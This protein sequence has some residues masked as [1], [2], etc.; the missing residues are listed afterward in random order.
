MKS[1]LARR[2]AREIAVQ[3]L[4][5]MEMNEVTAEVALR[6]AL[7]ELIEEEDTV[8]VDPSDD[9]QFLRSI[10]NGTS[11][12]V[13]QIDGVLEGYLTGWKMD[14]LS[15]VDRQIL[16]LGAYEMFFEE[17]TPDAVI[18]N[19]AIELAKHFG[20]DESGKFVNGVLGQ[21]VRERDQIQQ[22]INQS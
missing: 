9:V 10:V 1:K 11:T 16:R 8:T 3:T 6:A 20:T 22:K 21:M 19:E 12:H 18:L 15:K 17:G 7:E 14:R 13:E 4:Y 2:Q 5:Q